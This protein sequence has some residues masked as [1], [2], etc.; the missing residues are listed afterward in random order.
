MSRRCRACG[1]LGLS[2]VLDLG[3]VPVAD[4]FP[5][6]EVPQ[7]SS[8]VA[9]DLCGDCGLAQLADGDPVTC[10]PGGVAARVLQE[11]AR[12]AVARVATAGWL[13]GETLR[14][15]GSPHGGSWQRLLE[16]F[17]VTPEPGR[18]DIVLDSFGIMHE[19]DQRA[20]FAQRA[21]ATAPGGVLLLQYHALA[22]ILEQGQ[23]DALR[24]GH[25]AYYSVPAL[26]RLLAD[27]GMRLGSAWDFALYGGT[28]LVAAVHED[29][30][31]HADSVI[32]HMRSAERELIDPVTVA[33][34]Q[35]VADGQVVALQRY[36][37]HQR[38][39]GRR[40]FAYGA[41][42]RAVALFAR[43][44][45]DSE[46]VAAVGDASPGPAGRRMPGTDIAIVSPDVLASAA[47]D[48]VLLM[49]PELL[50]ELSTRLPE[51]AG[52]WV[53]YNAIVPQLG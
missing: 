33:T 19:P 28:T 20:A 9:M 49:V 15:F 52:R 40:V 12:D 50:P 2:R 16:Q 44:G 17:D 8:A 42:A 46:L 53:T 31:R 18:A 38:L 39:T 22:S 37:E 10:A 1:H 45:L 30:A 32:Q 34:L 13:T 24:H 47:P 4:V 11:Q 27:V 6:A 25:F 36:L 3:S 5:P 41:T 21:A 23:W 43:A 35:S 29:D 48:E 26:E 51:L 7:A 14:E